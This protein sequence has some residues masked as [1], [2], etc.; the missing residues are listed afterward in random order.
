MNSILRKTLLATAI[1]A[2]ISGPAWSADDA[3]ERSEDMPQTE[4][5]QSVEVTPPLEADP[6]IA[7]PDATVT[8]HP[9]YAL[10]P[11]DLRDLD[12]HDIEGEKIGSIKTVVQGPDS[13]TVHAVIAL[14][15][16]LGLGARDTVVPLD[17]LELAED[18]ARISATQEELEAHEEY[19]PELYVEL[20]PERPISEFSAFE[21]VPDQRDPAA[22]EP[23]SDEPGAGDVPEQPRMPQ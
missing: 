15:G 2:L 10:T 12:V 17:Q 7:S 14:G 3:V 4:P 8:E 19:V 6:G 16:F 13:G 9:I 1:A 21:Q 23:G 18:A 5:R 20:D 22:A 11:D